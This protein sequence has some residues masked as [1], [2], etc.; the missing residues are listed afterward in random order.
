MKMD[1]Y[2]NVELALRLGFEEINDIKAYRGKYYI[3]DELIWIHDIE[4]LK[5]RL[6]LD[7]DEGLR[8]LNY[9]VGSYYKYIDHTNEMVDEVLK[10]I[11]I[12]A[13]IDSS[14][15]VLSNQHILL[16]NKGKSTVTMALLEEGFDEEILADLAHQMSKK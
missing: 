2:K 16:S 13:A 6:N 5:T 1:Y 11:K 15:S 9:D 7:E 8:R 4:A 14:D 3:K 12:K 10:L